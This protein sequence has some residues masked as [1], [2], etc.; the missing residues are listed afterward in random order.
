MTDDVINFHLTVGYNS[1]NILAL[2]IRSRAFRVAGSWHMQHAC[3]RGTP[4]CRAGMEGSPDP[5]LFA[6]VQLHR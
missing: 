1:S 4:H 2:S 3:F 5:P 6:G